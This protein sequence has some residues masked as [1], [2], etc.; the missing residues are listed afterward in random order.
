MGNFVRLCSC[1]SNYWALKCFLIPRWKNSF[2]LVCVSVSVCIELHMIEWRLHCTQK[3]LCKCILYVRYFV[4]V[5]QKL[6]N[7]LF[8]LYKY[9]YKFNSHKKKLKKIYVICIIYW[10][11]LKHTT[12][13]DV[14]QIDVRFIFIWNGSDRI[15]N[16][17]FRILN[18][19]VCM[20]RQRIFK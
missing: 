12:A 3:F 15:F 5:C 6:M 13:S 14:V 4:C 10:N 9:T 8:Q 17:Q 1:L 18:I 20:K 2:F 16:L 11:G 19:P 7:V